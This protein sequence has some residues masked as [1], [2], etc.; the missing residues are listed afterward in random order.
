MAIPMLTRIHESKASYVFGLLSLLLLLQNGCAFQFIVGGSNGWAPSGSNAFNQWAES[1]RFQIDDSLVFNYAADQDSVLYVTK[2]D[3]TNCNTAYP[4]MKFTDGH[5]VYKFNQSG[6]HYF[7][8]GNEEHCHKNEK[9]VVVVMADR[10]DKYSN[11]PPPLES[12]PSPPPTDSY[13]PPPLE[14]YPPP[15]YSNSPPSPPPSEQSPD[16]P[17]D[18]NPT[19]PHKNSAAALSSITTFLCSFG[20]L[21]GSSLMLVL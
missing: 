7:I 3:Y 12:N 9:L 8:S 2:E 15:A 20:V 21:L 17:S 11:S 16:T 19:S 10:S 13:S 5:T 1:K 14:S 18:M 4:I 6:P